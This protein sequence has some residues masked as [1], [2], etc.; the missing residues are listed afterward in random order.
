KEATSEI[1]ALQ[2]GWKDIGTVPRR[3]SDKLWKRFRTACDYFFSRKSQ[4][5]QDIDSSFA[6]NLQMKE[7]IIKEMDEFNIRKDK[8]ENLKAV[9][10]FQNRFAATGFVSNNMKEKIKNQFWEAQE[11]LLKRMEINEHDRNMLKFKHRIR[12]I[13][14][15]SRAEMK[16]RFERDKLINKLQQLRNDIGV[17]ENNI[18]F[19]IESKSS[20]DTI[21][22][23]QERI[24][25]AHMR[26]KLLED[27]IRL[28]DD[29]ENEK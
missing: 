28:L 25:D 6:D 8:N 27:K 9:E 21:N 29:M 26:I 14:Q 13:L 20:Q 4:F 2:R 18:G 12:N 23:Y 11:R 10:D 3:E 22:G 7:Q 1:I 16:L 17:W 24:D 19:F 5:Y 15:S